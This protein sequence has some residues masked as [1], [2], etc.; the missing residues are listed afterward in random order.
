MWLISLMS[1][2]IGTIAKSSRFETYINY[3]KMKG[4]GI[5]EANTKTE[6]ICK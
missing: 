5:D 4:S 2:A 3:Q 6:D 1:K